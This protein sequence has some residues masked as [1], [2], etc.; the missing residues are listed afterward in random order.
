M[1]AVLP[2]NG[3]MELTEEDLMMIDGGKGFLHGAGFWIGLIDMAIDFGNGVV[4]GF[5][6]GLN[7]WK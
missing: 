1:E 2:M 7:A 4:D 3:F 6:D 5:K